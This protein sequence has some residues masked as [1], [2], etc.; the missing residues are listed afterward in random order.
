MIDISYENLFQIIQPSLSDGWVKLIVRASF[1]ED[2]CN[3]K[4]YI[5]KSDGNVCD[6]FNLD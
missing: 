1:V 5:K 6:C 2:S 3:V 4:Y